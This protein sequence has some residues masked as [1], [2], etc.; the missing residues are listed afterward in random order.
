MYYMTLLGLQ[1]DC[2][3]DLR[4]GDNA[5]TSPRLN[6]R[7]FSKTKLI[8]RSIEVLLATF[9]VEAIAFAMPN[10]DTYMLFAKCSQ[11]DLLT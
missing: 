4:Q 10:I 11:C 1:P 9:N 2:G 7:K 3:P 5:F 8:L 6:D